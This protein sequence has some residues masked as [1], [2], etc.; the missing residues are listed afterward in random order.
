LGD[1]KTALDNRALERLALRSFLGVSRTGSSMSNGSGDFAIAFS[2]AA[3]V[4][5]SPP[6]NRVTRTTEVVVNDGLSPLFQAVVEATEE[7]ILN[8]LFRA[9]PVRG[10]RGTMAAL[11][12]DSIIPI[13]REHRAIP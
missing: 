2:T 10:A 1:R 3:A 7:A 4:R 6:G 8:S 11:P 5:R 13:L 9:E 12:L